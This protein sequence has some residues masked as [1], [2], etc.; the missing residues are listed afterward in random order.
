M[1]RVLGREIAATGGR[2]ALL[3]LAAL[4]GLLVAGPRLELRFA[5]P[6]MLWEI[7]RLARDGD[8]VSFWVVA[9][10]ARPCR[11]VLEWSADGRPPRRE[12]RDLARGEAAQLGPFHVAGPAARLDVEARFACGAPWSPAPI[13]KSAML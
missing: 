9:H 10:A 4:F 7:E 1:M 5:P 11:V 3:V 6:V 8:G 13:R 2:G 12:A